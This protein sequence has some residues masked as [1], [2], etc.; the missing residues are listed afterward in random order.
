MAH[1][2]IN[3]SGQDMRTRDITSKNT[4]PRIRWIRRAA[5]PP[6]TIRK[7][8]NVILIQTGAHFKRIISDFTA[9]FSCKMQTNDHFE[10]AGPVFLVTFLLHRSSSTGPTLFLCRAASSTKSSS[11]PVHAI[12]VRRGRTDGSSLLTKNDWR[13]LNRKY[14]YCASEVH[15]LIS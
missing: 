7:K 5:V 14:G 10:A 8:S 11:Q 4:A 3:A 15:R 1:A 13:C 6:R 2:K 12:F 9:R